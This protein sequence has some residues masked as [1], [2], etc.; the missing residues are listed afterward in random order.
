MS[1]LIVGKCLNQTR[2]RKT[3]KTKVLEGCRSKTIYSYKVSISRIRNRRSPFNNKSNRLKRTSSKSHFSP[4]V[5]IM[6]SI[7]I[8]GPINRLNISLNR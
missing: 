3:S 5:R 7:L 1:A 8:K 2:V 4:R 6:V